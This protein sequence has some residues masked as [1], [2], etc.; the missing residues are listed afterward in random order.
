MKTKNNDHDHS[1][2]WLAIWFLFMSD[3]A[4]C[5]GYAKTYQIP[6]DMEVQVNQ[7][8]RDISRLESELNSLKYN[9]TMRRN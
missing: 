2:V 4:N 9:L 7:C 3:C 1:G 5:N 8:Q 6:R